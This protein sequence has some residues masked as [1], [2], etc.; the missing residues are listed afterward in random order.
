MHGAD[1]R[2]QRIGE[3]GFQPV[4]AAAPD[5]AAEAEVI[6]ELEPLG[7]LRQS[8]LAHQAG[9]Q[10]RQF[11]FA[12][13]RL[14]SEQLVR[15]HVAEH[16]ITQELQALVVNP[17]RA[18]VGKRLIQQCPVDE[19]VPESPFEIGIRRPAR[20]CLRSSRSASRR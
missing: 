20:G 4:T 5:A 13:A 9:A 11:V 14:R 17:A 15:H 1:H 16:G 18:L 19:T 12:H 7:E 2:F 3:N 6:S 8:F 10:Q